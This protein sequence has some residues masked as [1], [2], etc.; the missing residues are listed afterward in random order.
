MRPLVGWGLGGACFTARDVPSQTARVGEP[1]WGPNALLRDLE[2]R[3]GVPTPSESASVR[4]PRW[5]ARIRALSDAKAFYARSFEVDAI[6]TATT[7]L[8]WR[9]ALADGGPSSFGAGRWS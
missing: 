1:T 5:A 8:A 3:L 4:V 6:G 9:D 7:L 2:M